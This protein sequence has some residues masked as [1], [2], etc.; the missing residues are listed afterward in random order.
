MAYQP[1]GR[2]HRGPICHA[3]WILVCII[4]FIIYFQA[5]IALVNEDKILK[6]LTIDLFVVTNFSLWRHWYTFFARVL[7]LICIFCTAFWYMGNCDVTN[8]MPCKFCI[9]DNDKTYCHLSCIAI[10]HNMFLSYCDT[11]I[12]LDVCII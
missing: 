6:Y 8:I 1:M 4:L 11:P 2:G 10:Y 7:I 12:R 9:Y 3:M 5:E